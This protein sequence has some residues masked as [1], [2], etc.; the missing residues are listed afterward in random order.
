YPYNK[1]AFAPIGAKAILL[2]R[3]NENKLF[4][5]HQIP[6]IDVPIRLFY[7]ALDRGESEHPGPQFGFTSTR[8]I[9]TLSR[10]GKRK[11]RN[12]SPF[13]DMKSRVAGYKLLM[14]QNNWTQA[15]LSRHLGVSRAWVTK[16]FKVID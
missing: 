6:G 3:C 16:V 10:R 13:A 1:I 5:R 4:I 2:P 9:A 15:E 11:K 8:V 12:S 14:D 7:R